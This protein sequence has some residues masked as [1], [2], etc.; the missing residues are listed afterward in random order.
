[1]TLIVVYNFDKHPP[2]S[3]LEGQGKEG[4]LS[5]GEFKGLLDFAIEEYIF[6]KD[7]I[8][9]NPISA[10]QFARKITKEFTDLKENQQYD[11]IREEIVKTIFDIARV[12]ER[13]M[14][15]HRDVRRDLADAEW[16]ARMVR[17]INQ[18]IND[19]ELSGLIDHLW[20]C[21]NT[22]FW[23]QSEVE[24][25]ISGV[26]GV[27]TAAHLLKNLDLDLRLATPVE[28]VKHKIDLWGRLEH[29]DE[30]KVMAIQV[31]TSKNFLRPYLREVSSD[32][33]KIIGLKKQCKLL[34]QELKK[35]ES[36]EM[37]EIGQELRIAESK[38]CMTEHLKQLKKENPDIDFKSYWLN[39]PGYLGSG[40][41]DL[42]ISTGKPKQTMINQF[43]G[44]YKDLINISK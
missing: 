1:M 38:I 29:G 41:N 37:P 2:L 25:F 14:G 13:G 23:E 22:K 40:A 4:K 3:I 39:I 7:E 5:A 19:P 16:Q 6:N 28:D 10:D 34:R 31:K 35:C 32:K 20:E 12:I 43:C 21:F 15:F 27:V 17:L 11:K 9:E 18:H 8:L 30:Q 24:P 44:E 26:K 33:D 42:E 36:E